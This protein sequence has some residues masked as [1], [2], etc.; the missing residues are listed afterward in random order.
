MFLHKIISTMKYLSDS[1]FFAA[2][3]IILFFLF[4]Y[5]FINRNNPIPTNYPFVGMLP[6]LLL[7]L[8]R[9]QDN[10]TD[11]LEASNGSFLFKGPWLCRMRLILT[12]DPVN[13][14]YVMSKNFS[15][16]PKGPEFKEIFDILGDGIMNVDGEMW[17]F[18]RQIAHSFI[19]HDKF[20]RF[21]IKTIARKIEDG[22][23]PILDRA[24]L[25]GSVVDL[26]ELFNRLGIDSICLFLTGRDP[27]CLNTKHEENAFSKALD[28]AEEALFFRNAMP[29]AVWKL[30]RW[31]NIGT[32][33]KMKHARKVLDEVIYELIEAKKREIKNGDANK[34]EEGVDLLTLYMNKNGSANKWS[35]KFLRDTVLNLTVAGRDS[36]GA[37]LSWLFWLLIKNP[38]AEVKIE[39]E[40]KDVT[41]HLTSS[42][43]ISIEDLSK[44]V[45]LQ[46]TLCETL[47][48]YPPVAIQ[49]KAPVAPDILPTGHVVDRG[50][51]IYFFMYA[52]GRTKSIWGE[53]C[54]EF[55]PER[56]INDQGKLKH[57][58]SYKFFSFNA[59]PRTCIGKEMGLIQIKAIASSL[60]LKYRFEVVK[61]HQ[62]V[63]D[64][65]SVIL[66]MKHGLKVRVF[67]KHNG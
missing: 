28:H 33:R 12:S 48:L 9:I 59:G 64:Q 2:P 15:N 61:G 65:M 1:L 39:K 18:Q 21:L 52:M 6:S 42:S 5:V 63:P 60:I 47:R 19:G 55:K 44:M 32:E 14:H 50:T 38:E 4:I 26:K 58:P 66:N 54:L 56:W 57:E 49:N 45:Y 25:D 22:L 16:F 35:N 17:K 23:I 10:V 41:G 27:G 24:V 8:R 67:K 62:V 20:R 34:D 37:T 7:N 13:V 30:F 3:I 29:K 40:I 51:K 46:G 36:S 31:L 43:D 53:D 11:I